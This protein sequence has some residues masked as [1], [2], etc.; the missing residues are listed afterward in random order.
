M[1]SLHIARMDVVVLKNREM[2]DQASMRYLSWNNTL[3]RTLRALGLGAAPSVSPKP[4]A[5]AEFTGE[6][7]A[8]WPSAGP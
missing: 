2:S 6:D 4:D 3:T 5:F 1:L 7:P 8:T